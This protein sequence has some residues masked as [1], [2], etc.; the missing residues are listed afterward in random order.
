MADATVDLAGDALDAAEHSVAQA[1][2]QVEP[3]KCWA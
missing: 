1:S 3:F 2:S